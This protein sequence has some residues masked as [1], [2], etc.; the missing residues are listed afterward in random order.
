[1][2]EIRACAPD[3]AAAVTTLLSELGYTVPIR[4]ATENSKSSAKPGRR[5]NSF[6]TSAARISA[7]R[8]ACACLQT[9]S[10]DVP[11]RSATARFESPVAIARS[12]CGRA[13]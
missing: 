3:D 1:M 8:C 4:Q 11:K 12:I 7:V 9:A 5:C 10:R 6:V 2:N 13:G